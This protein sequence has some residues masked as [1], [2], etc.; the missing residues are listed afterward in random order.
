M[1]RADFW[2]SGDWNSVCYECGRKRKASQLKKHWQGYYVCPEHWEPRQPQDFVR[3]IQDV[4]TVPWSQPLSE[5]F[6][7]VSLSIGLVDG[8]EIFETF[9]R[10]FD[11]TFIDV[12]PGTG[13]TNVKPTNYGATNA[14]LVSKVGTPSMAI[15]ETFEIANLEMVSDVL[16]VGEGTTFVVGKSLADSTVVFEGL[17]LNV[18][19]PL[20]DSIPLNETFMFDLQKPFAESAAITESFVLELSLPIS[21]VTNASPINSFVTNR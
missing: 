5:I 18:Q 7:G 21:G 11:L 6:S 16:G 14:Q 3:G 2:A 10:L 1:G 15:S 8:L 17:A 19:R 20:N 13:A 4:Q 9:T 12:Y